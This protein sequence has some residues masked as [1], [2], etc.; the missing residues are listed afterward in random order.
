MKTAKLLYRITAVL[1]LASALLLNGCLHN[2]I[3]SF[4]LSS[5]QPIEE[6]VPAYEAL[7]QRNDLVS[8]QDY[9]IEQTVRVMNALELAQANSVD[10]DQFLEYMAKQDYSRVAPDVLEAKQKML[11]VLQY[12]YKLRSLDQNLSDIW[13]LARGISAGAE[14]LAN[15]S[16]AFTIS[17]LLQG[18]PYS[19]FQLIGIHE[20]EQAVEIVKEHYVKDKKLKKA[21]ETDLDKL[22]ASYLAYL[23]DY[24]PIYQKYMKEYDALC[25]EKDN[26]YLNVFGGN[27]EE[28][29]RTAERLLE[30]YPDNSEL[31]LLKVTSELLISEEIIAMEDSQKPTIEINGSPLG[32]N[33]ELPSIMP[34]SEP[35]PEQEPSPTY[36]SNDNLLEAENTIERYL[37]VYPDRSAPALLLKGIACQQMG[38]TKTAF[39]YFNQASIEYPRQAELL[40]DMLESY[41]LRT[42]LYK[43]SE[44]LY[45][46]QLNRS[47]MEGYGSF[48]PNLLKAKY[49]ADNGMME[50]SKNEIYNHFFR[51]GNQGVYDGLLSDLQFCENHLY[52]SFKDLLIDN[53]LLEVSIGRVK[54]WLFWKKDDIVRVNINNLSDK[55]FEN[56][57]LF[58]CIHYTDM[59]KD[60][61]DVVRVSKVLNV[62][63]SHTTVDMDTVHLRYQDKKYDDITRISAIAITD[64]R[65]C[66]ID[67]AAL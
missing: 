49:Y 7:T 55:D 14:N 32:E 2:E 19:I 60:E 59:Y 17:Q 58:L 37:S 6:F 8:N 66:L 12:M 26:V 30:K 33:T 9:D 18:N 27:V 29:Q 15:T 50:A 64:D 21:L 51:R 35:A 5:Y 22:Q 4:D 36:R 24:L 38:D 46:L 44:G 23:S 25:M 1:V 56:V 40:T 48:S 3:N 47:V 67:E 57:R 13:M 41:K 39:S 16:N 10:F 43:T 53:S 28:A 65:I 62:L 42:H 34:E 54:K 31:L 11:P 61:Y 45:L 52:D 63:P 20:A